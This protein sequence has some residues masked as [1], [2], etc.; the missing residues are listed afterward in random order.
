MEINILNRLYMVCPGV[1]YCLN[2]DPT[3]YLREVYL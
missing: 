3:F 2:V 1:D